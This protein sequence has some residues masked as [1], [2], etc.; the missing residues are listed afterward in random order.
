MVHYTG[1]IRKMAHYT[2]RVKKSAIFGKTLT[3][4][5]QML[6][7]T[8]R[9]MKSAIFGT[10]L[11]VGHQ[12]VP[13]TG[14]LLRS[15]IFGPTLTVGYH[16]VALYRLTDDKCNFWPHFVIRPPNVPLYSL[17][18]EKYNLGPTLLLGHQMVHYTIWHVKITILLVRSWPE[19]CNHFFYMACR[20]SDLVCLHNN[21]KMF[22][23]STTG[24]KISFFRPEMQGALERL[25]N[26]SPW[27]HA[28]IPPS[29]L[30]TPEV[31]AAEYRRS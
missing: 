21:S 27:S 12:M 6:P 30:A 17:T 19:V 2:G 11:T 4:G 3:V 23:F 29:I 20:I 18:G 14:W 7:Y 10:T 31:A 8:G 16:M 9:V 26:D 25:L 24:N 28:F 5:H 13:Y 1:I 22:L 15:A